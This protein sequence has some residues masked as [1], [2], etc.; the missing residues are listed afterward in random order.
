MD[1]CKCLRQ[2]CDICEPRRHGLCRLAVC[3]HH[4][5]DVRSHIH[6]HAHAAQVFHGEHVGGAGPDGH[7]FEARLYAESPRSGF[8]PGTSVCV[9]WVALWVVWL[10]AEENRGRGHFKE[11]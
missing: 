8:L 11:A 5:I 4:Q 10:C 1:A 3:K 9:K 6:K 2:M 7:A